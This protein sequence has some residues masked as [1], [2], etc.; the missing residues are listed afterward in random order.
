MLLSDRIVMMTN[1][2]AARIGEVLS[3]QEVGECD[4]VRKLLRKLRIPSALDVDDVRDA[5]R[6]G[7]APGARSV[8][9]APASGGRP[10]ATM[11]AS[12]P[13]ACRPRP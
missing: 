11:S 8:L 4:T 10:S 3:E 13:S 6:R 12:D 5:M 9:R 7:R 1:G 2:P